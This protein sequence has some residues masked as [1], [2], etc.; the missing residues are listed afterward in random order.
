MSA[1]IEATRMPFGAYCA[2][3]GAKLFAHADE[4]VRA[5][6]DVIHASGGRVPARSPLAKSLGMYVRAATF[7]SAGH[8]PTGE[9]AS[10]VMEAMRVRFVVQAV[11]A[12]ERHNVQ[13]LDERLRE[14]GGEDVIISGESGAQSKARDTMWEIVTAGLC[15]Q[16]AKAV[17]MPDPPDVV[18]DFEGTRWGVECKMLRSSS[19]RRQMDRVVK[20]A[21]QIERH[22]DS[23]RGVVLLNVT[24]AI[25]HAPWSEPME[26]MVA[27]TMFELAV[28]E[29]VAGLDRRDLFRRFAERPKVRT[30]MLFA[31]TMLNTG[32]T[33][34]L[35]TSAAWPRD[36]PEAGHDEGEKKL[37]LAFND[38][39]YAL[40]H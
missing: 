17:A 9:D 16:F 2:D 23:E 18:C 31:Q 4:E 12:A 14:I 35:T 28:G 36:I 37:L 39:A 5:F 30:F 13:H 40:S 19:G 21:D 24:D 34:I 22:Q 7:L 33:A 15:T 20:G 29:A 38:A 32:D 3:D 26:A 10:D 27:R 8:E 11:L 25:F 1:R 6:R